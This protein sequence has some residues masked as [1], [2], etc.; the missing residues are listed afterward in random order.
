MMRESKINA[1][2]NWEVHFSN[3]LGFKRGFY[4][5]LLIIFLIE[6]ACH[7]DTYK[8]DD[9]DIP[10]TLKTSTNQPKKRILMT[11]KKIFEAFDKNVIIKA[12][13]D[14]KSQTSTTNARGF[15][16]IFPTSLRRT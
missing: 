11:H 5:K 8:K 15:S 12:Y 10:D 4:G 1:S 13:D 7:N 14:N 16:K 9:A 2:S 6:N 3:S